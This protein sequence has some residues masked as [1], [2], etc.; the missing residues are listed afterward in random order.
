VTVAANLTALAV[1]TETNGS[2]VC[3]ATANGV[4][5]IKPTVGLI[6]RSGIVPISH[7]QDTAGPF[8]R[9]VSDAVSLLAAMIGPD[10]SDVITELA[11]EVSEWE[12]AAHLVEDGL[13]GKRIGVLRS[14]T[15]YHSDVDSLLEQAIGDLE[16]AGAVIIDDL[17][18]EAPQG[19]SQAAYDVLLYEFKHD[20]NAYLASLPDATL[21]ALTL[22][23]L[24]SFNKEHADREMP[25]FEQEIFLK[26]QAK[27]PLSEQEYL[28]ALELVQNAS[29]RD[30]IDRLISEY[31]L[32]ALVAPTGAP[33]WKI[34][35]INGDHYMGS[36]S[37]YPARAGYPHITVPMGH[38]QSMPVGLSFMGAALSEPVLIEIAYAYE[39]RTGHRIPP[40]P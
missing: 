29:G 25:H 11:G 16:N 18:F 10:E 5:G 34:D 31:E 19:L 4:V 6:S 20:L 21:S 32:N 24:I 8:G 28:I 9:T 37:S 35:L 39:R 30:G 27:G 33:A 22:E 2:V 15:G 38:V 17:A 36:C 26:S 23:G 14:A 1:G 3:P 13:Q 40:E 7:S 12:L